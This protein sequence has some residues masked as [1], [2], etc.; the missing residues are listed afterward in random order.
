VVKPDSTF[1]TYLTRT[2]K[3]EIV[4]KTNNETWEHLLQSISGY[5]LHN[6]ENSHIGPILTGNPQSEILIST[7]WRDYYCGPLRDDRPDPRLKELIQILL[8]NS[9]KNN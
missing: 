7:N 6:L 3:K 4:K 9:A 1:S 2:V 5:Q 8:E